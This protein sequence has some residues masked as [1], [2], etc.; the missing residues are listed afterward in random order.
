MSVQGNDVRG[1]DFLRRLE[2]HEER[3]LRAAFEETR[4]DGPGPASS[5][6]WV[7]LYLNRAFT[8]DHA[9]RDL[10]HAW[11]LRIVAEAYATWPEVHVLAYGFKTNPAKNPHGQPFHV[12]YTT[13]S[14]NL[15][16]PLT[17]ITPRN[18]TEFIRQPL[19]RAEL[20]HKA[21]LGSLDDIFDAEG[22]DAVEIVQLVC[23]PYS[24]IRLLP[25]TPHRGIAN[26]EDEDRIMFFVTV[27]DHY[28]PL[29]ETPVFAY[30]T[31]LYAP[32]TDARAALRSD[33][34]VRDERNETLWRDGH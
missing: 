6:H 3:L 7:N 5:I 16:V 28:H 19:T 27:D 30:S 29:A 23:R 14:S 9:H 12:D 32:V 31:E 17:R 15:F 10:L 24:L 13:T 2:E 26:G 34:P 20:D 18:A 1:M 11:V 33:A 4:V 21:E 22:C 8:Q 25:N